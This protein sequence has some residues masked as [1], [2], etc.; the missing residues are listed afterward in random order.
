[1]LGIDQMLIHIHSFSGGQWVKLYHADRFG[2][3]DRRQLVVRG[4][5]FWRS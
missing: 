2:W 5:N 1:M 4:M 3:P